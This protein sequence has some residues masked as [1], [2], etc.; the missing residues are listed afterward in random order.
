MAVLFP[1][2]ICVALISFWYSV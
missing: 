2:K 1:Q